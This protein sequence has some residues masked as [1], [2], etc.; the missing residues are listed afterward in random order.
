MDCSS[1][2]D[3]ASLGRTTSVVRLGGDV[4]DRADLQAG[5]LQ[6]PDR[7]LAAR[8]RAL[9]EHVDLAHPVLLGLA[10]G[11]L[12]GQL[13]GER[14]RLP[15]T[16]EANIARRRPDDDVA[17]WVGDRDDRV[18]ERALD[19]RGAVRDVLLFP[20]PGLLTLSRRWA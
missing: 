10:C 3:P 2:L 19:V 16:L 13:S 14:G 7:G 1:S 15:R 5:G 17:L 8:A 12:G 9:H 4:G 11:V 6:R 18:V 20:P